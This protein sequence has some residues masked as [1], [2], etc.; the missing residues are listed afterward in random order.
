MALC[1]PWIL[2]GDK[3][4]EIWNINPAVEEQGWR[5][6]TNDIRVVFCGAVEIVCQATVTVRPMTG[7]PGEGPTML[8]G[9]QLDLLPFGV[10]K[11]FVQP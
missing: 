10:H 3:T 8:V 5:Y 1:I 2:E 11:Y 6:G 4:M 9:G 7:R